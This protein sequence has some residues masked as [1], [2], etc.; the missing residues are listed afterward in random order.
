MRGAS[1]G[2]F[3]YIGVEMGV[4]GFSWGLAEFDGTLYQ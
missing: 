1:A 4:H 2:L 3:R